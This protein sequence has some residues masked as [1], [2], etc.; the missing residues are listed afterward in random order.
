MTTRTARSPKPQLVL[1]VLRREH[2][3]PHMVR[4][5]IGGENFPMLLANDHTDAYIKIFFAKPELGLEPP[6]HLAELREALAPEDLPVTR[7]YTIRAIDR[8]QGWLAVD[9][10][11]HGEAGIAGPW[12]AKAEPGAPVVFAGPGGGYSPDPTADWHLL[13]GDESALPA[14]AAA[15]EALAPEAVGVAVIEVGS[16]VDEQPLR[17][18]AGVE[19]HWVH[20][21]IAEAGTSTVLVDAVRDVDWRP[22]R[23]HVFA[24]GEREAVK[25]LRDIFF[26]DHALERRQV[27]ISGYWAYGRSEETFQAEKRTPIGQILPPEA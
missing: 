17:A 8:D 12:A 27:S 22:G 23:V 9:F 18:P 2:L 1:E 26:T 7:T 19:I 3:T 13:A 4:L 6:Y 16:E 15:L 10:V 21:G 5:Y 24:H 20:R 14:I 25:Q 11:V